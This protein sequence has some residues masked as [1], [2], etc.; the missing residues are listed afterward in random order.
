[1]IDGYDEAHYKWIGA[2]YL[3]QEMSETIVE[4]RGL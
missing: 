3:H 1:M 4:G 2:L